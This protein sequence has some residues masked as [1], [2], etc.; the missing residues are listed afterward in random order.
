MRL[1]RATALLLP[2][3]TACYSYSVAGPNLRGGQHVQLFL[4]DRGRV[5]LGALLGAGTRSVSGDVADASDST[6]QLRV[7]GTRTIDGA[8]YAW[9]GERVRISRAL[10]DS[11]RVQRV[12]VARTALVA[13]GITGGALL[14]RAAFS[15]GLGGG[16]QRTPGTS[17]R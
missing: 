2:A 9:N 14:V 10:V 17:S 12:A 3:I 5:E 13:A 1:R 15:G 6:L 4:S 8:E 16:G 7:S 11:V